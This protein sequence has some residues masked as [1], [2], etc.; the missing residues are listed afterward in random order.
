MSAII[1]NS[2]GK[3]GVLRVI[4]TTAAALHPLSQAPNAA[5]NYYCKAVDMKGFQVEVDLQALPPGVN[6]TQIQP[7]QVWWVEKRTTLYRLY[8]FAGIYDPITR[9]I[10]S[11]GLLP[12]FPP[13]WASYYDTTNQIATSA[14]Q[15]YVVSFNTVVGQSGF[16]LV[17]GSQITAL[18]AGVYNFQFTAQFA[19]TNAGGTATYNTSVW[20]RQNG[21]DLPWTGGEISIYAKSPYALPS[22]NFVQQMNAGDYVELV[23]AVDTANQIYVAAQPSVANGYS[24][25]WPKPPYGT[26]IPSWTMTVCQA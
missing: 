4:I 13:T 1:K 24:P 15:P 14:N 10:D 16:T 20:M 12:Q 6:Y 26:S 11:T 3:D 18:A 25:A 9:R 21:V 8:L 7:N 2:P 5:Q 17:S 22:W 23:W 19:L